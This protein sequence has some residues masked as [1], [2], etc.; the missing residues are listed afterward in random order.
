MDDDASV[1]QIVAMKAQ[2]PLTLD[3]HTAL[4][5]IDVQRNF[6]DAAYGFAQVVEKLVPGTTQ[7]YFYA[8]RPWSSP[9]FSCCFASSANGACLF[10]LPQPERRWRTVVISPVGCGISISSVCSCSETGSGRKRAQRRG[11]STSRLHL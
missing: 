4:L 7:G 2:M 8:S 5:I 10:S 6:V 11:R 9:I 1:M 3:R